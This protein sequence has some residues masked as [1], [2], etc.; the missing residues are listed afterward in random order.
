M[1]ETFI[2]VLAWFGLVIGALK[3]AAGIYVW[4]ELNYT[5]HGRLRQSLAGVQGKKLVAN[6]PTP[7]IIMFF[8]SLAW[9]ITTWIS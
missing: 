9:L 5:S 4:N 6:K 7:W 3:T 2:T 1:I 8:V